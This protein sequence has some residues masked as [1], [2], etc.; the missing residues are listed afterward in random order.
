LKQNWQELTTIFQ[1][2]PMM[3]DTV[4]KIKRKET[5]ENELR[6]LE[7][8]IASIEQNPIIYIDQGAGDGCDADHIWID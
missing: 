3:T 1:G 4:A 6:Q 5:L 2:L 7:K 8:D